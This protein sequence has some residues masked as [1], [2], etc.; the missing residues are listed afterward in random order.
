ME[1]KTNK[2]TIATIISSV[3]AAILI[4]LNFIGIEVGLE[5][6]ILFVAITEMLLGI[7]QHEIAKN[8]DK[9]RDKITGNLCFAVGIIVMIVLIYTNI[10]MS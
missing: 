1:S 3:I 7:G 2:L 4:L 8:S 10:K 9:K 6:G 5:I